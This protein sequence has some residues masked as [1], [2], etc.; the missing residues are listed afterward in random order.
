MKNKK[1]H[2]F[3]NESDAYLNSDQSDSYV[4]SD[5]TTAQHARKN[6]SKKSRFDERRKQKFSSQSLFM[7]FK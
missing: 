2:L 5:S 6:K 4:R 1:Q 7:D 3:L